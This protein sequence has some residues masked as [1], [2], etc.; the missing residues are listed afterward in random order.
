MYF[1][2]LILTYKFSIVAT[3]NN[4][5]LILSVTNSEMPMISH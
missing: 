5:P 1:A 4:I 2:G 3:A